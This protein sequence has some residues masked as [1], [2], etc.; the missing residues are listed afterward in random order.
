MGF[1]AYYDQFM[2]YNRLSLEE[3]RKSKQNLQTIQLHQLTTPKALKT[4]LYFYKLCTQIKKNCENE[5][6]NYQK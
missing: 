1:H 5:K 4:K 6:L 2:C 3:R